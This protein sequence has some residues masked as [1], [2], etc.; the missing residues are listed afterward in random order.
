MRG[1]VSGGNQVWCAIVELN[2]YYE[3]ILNLVGGVEYTVFLGR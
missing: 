3:R 2:E 1:F